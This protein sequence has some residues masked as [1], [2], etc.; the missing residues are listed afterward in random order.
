MKKTTYLLLLSIFALFSCTDNEADNRTSTLEIIKLE[1][2]TLCGWCVGASQ[3]VISDSEAEYIAFD[4]CQ[5]LDPQLRTLETSEIEA[6]NQHL[7]DIDEQAIDLDH[8]GACYDGCEEG[9]K[10]VYEDGT[11]HVI[12]FDNR[13]YE[14]VDQLIQL[15]NLLEE[16]QSDF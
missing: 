5:Q 4:G 7:E 2:N 3:L 16:I 9:M 8:C 10:F 14:E 12:L 1:Y 15:L 6:L 11:E 13:E